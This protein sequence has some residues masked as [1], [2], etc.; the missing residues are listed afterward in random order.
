MEIWKIQDSGENS[1]R[2][3][4]RPIA[5]KWASLPL[6]SLLVKLSC[7]QKA[8]FRLVF[9]AKEEKRFEKKGKAL[10]EKGR[11][12]ALLSGVVQLFKATYAGPVCVSRSPK[13]LHTVIG[14]M[15]QKN[16][17]LTIEIGAFGA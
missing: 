15:T 12:E 16:T 6:L 9:S 3:R 10:F 13:R 8:S 4:K 11:A 2:W 7:Q 5:K 17:R 14:D 1:A